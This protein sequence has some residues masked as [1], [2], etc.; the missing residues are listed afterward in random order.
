MSEMQENNTQETLNETQN[1]NIG[2][3]VATGDRLDSDH[4]DHI[5][6]EDLGKEGWTGGDTGLWIEP[7]L[8]VPKEVWDYFRNQDSDGDGID[9]WMKDDS[10]GNGIDAFEEIG[11]FDD[12]LDFTDYF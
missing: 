1:Q 9:D 6:I 3:Q 12:E 2:T 8:D 4:F 10:D 11:S 7:P 5:N